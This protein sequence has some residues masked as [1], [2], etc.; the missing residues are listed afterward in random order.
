M[1]D[2][3]CKSTGT[4]VFCTL[5]LP[6]PFGDSGCDCIPPANNEL[7]FFT[8]KS[9]FHSLSWNRVAIIPQQYSKVR[10]LVS[11]KGV[12]FKL[13]SLSLSLTHS[14]SLSLLY[15]ISL[16]PP[17][18]FL[19]V[20]LVYWHSLTVPIRS[21]TAPSVRERQLLESGTLLIWACLHKTFQS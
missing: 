8:D 6:S 19:S 5:R 13:P 7:Y 12:S 18:L 20:S 21:S 10:W 15:S 1:F 11:E 14:L 17:T 4:F 9:T 16:P 3:H 2:C